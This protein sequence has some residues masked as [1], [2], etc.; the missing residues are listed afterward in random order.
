MTF[1]VFLI[2][3]ILSVISAFHTTGMRARNTPLKMDMKFNTKSIS[4][5]AMAA[6]SALSINAATPAYA[7]NYGGFGKGA[8]AVISPKDAVV[9]EVTADV[10]SG[11]DS[12]SKYIASVKSI[13]ADLAKNP[14]ADLVSSMKS[15]L[16]SAPLRDTLNKFN[17]AFDEDTQKG[18]DRLIR[19]A[20][21]DVTELQREVLVKEGKARSESKAAIVDKRLSALEDA[22]TTLASCLK[23]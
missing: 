18:T 1:T 14:N 19:V 9:L 15:S 2:F 5:G 10:K 23:Q 3:S 21:Q 13:R 22:L 6:I 11:A 20:L 12:L 16:Q 17:S 7:A 4:I 8:T